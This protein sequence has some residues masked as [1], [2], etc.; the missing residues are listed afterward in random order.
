MIHNSVMAVVLTSHV[1]VAQRVVPV[2]RGGSENARCIPTTENH[3]D[4]AKFS[5][6]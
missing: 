4:A 2:T 3:S 5:D 6:K 1:V